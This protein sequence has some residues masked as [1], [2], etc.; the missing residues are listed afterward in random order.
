MFVNTLQDI[1]LGSLNLMF[2]EFS[3][4]LKLITKNWFIIYDYHIQFY[5]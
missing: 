3:M 5:N 4:K 1:I 2:G